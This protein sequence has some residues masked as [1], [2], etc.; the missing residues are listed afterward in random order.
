MRKTIKLAISLNIILIIT[1][2]ILIAVSTI[3]E[4]PKE[5]VQQE[6]IIIDKISQT[7]EL[8]DSEITT[9]IN[10]KIEEPGYIAKDNIDG[11]ITS[12]VIIT[13]NIDTTKPRISYINYEVKDSNNKKTTTTTNVIIEKNKITRKKT[14]TNT[15]TSNKEIND[16]IKVIND[17]L[18]NY[19]V[20]VGYI[21]MEN[22]FT[23]I[24]N[25]N[26]E[27]FGASLIKVIDSMYIYENNLNDKETT[28]LVKDAISISSNPA[29]AS[30]VKKIGIKNYTNYMKKISNR[31]VYCN[32]RTFCQTTVHDQLS[33]WI[34][35]Y[36]L[37]EEHPDSEELKS[38][39]INNLGNHLSYTQKFDNLHK[40]G[41]SDEYYHDVGIFYEDEPYIIVVLT[42]EIGS[43]NKHIKYLIRGISREINILNDL[44]ETHY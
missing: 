37:L 43:Y 18:S 36:Y 2:S 32:E 39:Y 44:V 42:K 34:Y 40:Y 30:L 1:I 11:D 12:K 10:T 28:E 26:K 19:K 25:G 20:S 35:L 15:K 13:N 33:Y 22:G 31:E 17:Y 41:A 9:Q 8:I 4:P 21:N 16:K 14:Y 24:Y 38:F 3:K 6:K 5:Q 7:I 27:Y 29:H 23:Y